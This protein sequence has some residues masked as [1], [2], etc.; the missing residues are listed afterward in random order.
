MK[1]I[2]YSELRQ[3]LKLNLDTVTDNNEML[4]VQ[5]PKGRSLVVLSLDEY[6][7]MKETNH[8]MSTKNNRQRLEQAVNN[9]NS[10]QNLIK[11]E[12]ID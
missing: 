11:G 7:A 3:N 8:L 2:N 9:I 4:I 5:R 12:P 6:N 10:K 1:A